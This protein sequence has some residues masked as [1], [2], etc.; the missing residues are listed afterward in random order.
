[1]SLFCK[2]Q[3]MCLEVAAYTITTQTKCESN[4]IYFIAVTIFVNRD[5][6]VFVILLIK[7][8]PALLLLLSFSLKLTILFYSIPATQTNRLQIFLNSASWSGYHQNS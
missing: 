4:L 3:I 5:F 8:Q 1:M 2:R 7:L 6:Y